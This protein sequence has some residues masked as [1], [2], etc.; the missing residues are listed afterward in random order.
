MGAGVAGVPMRELALVILVAAALTYLTTG[1]VRYSMVRSGRMGEIRE[2]DVHTQPKP[3]LGGVAMFTGFL[4]AVFL[5]DQLPAL[6]RGFQPITPEMSAVIWA[7]VVRSW[8]RR[9]QDLT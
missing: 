5:A 6:T 9:T 4:G 8:M 3:R 1:I 2:R 7:G